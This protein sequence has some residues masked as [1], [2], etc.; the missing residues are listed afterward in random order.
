MLGVSA[1]WPCWVISAGSSPTSC[2]TGCFIDERSPICRSGTRNR[3]ELD[4]PL[5]K[6]ARSL[7]PLFQ[8]GRIHAR[9]ERK[10]GR[11]TALTR[12]TNS[13][14]KNPEQIAPGRAFRFIVQTSALRIARHEGIVAEFGDLEPLVPLVREVGQRFVDLLEIGI[15]CRYFAVQF[16][17][18]LEARLH[19]GR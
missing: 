6:Q 13:A 7:R 1:A 19:D 5:G 4:R 18:R 15:C 14:R 3:V 11:K 8:S 2:S 9:S 10:D 17:R 12:S 16:F